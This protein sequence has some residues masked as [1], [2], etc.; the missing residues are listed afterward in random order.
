M[1]DRRLNMPKGSPER[2]AA[3]KEEIISTTG[4]TT[5]GERIRECRIDQGLSQEALAGI[6]H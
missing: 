1:K 6:W 2:T 5:V 4:N 3:R